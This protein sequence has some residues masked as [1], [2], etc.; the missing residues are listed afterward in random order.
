MCRFWVSGFW[1]DKPCSKIMVF[2][3]LLIS[4]SANKL[5]KNIKTQ[6]LP[7]GVWD[8]SPLVDSVTHQSWR[9]TILEPYFNFF[10]NACMKNLRTLNWLLCFIIAG[11]KQLKLPCTLHFDARSLSD[12]TEDTFLKNEKWDSSNQVYTYLWTSQSAGFLHSV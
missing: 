9:T 6:A 5:G 11:S 2:K 7:Q 12:L 3:L 1:I 8:S 10:F 4:G